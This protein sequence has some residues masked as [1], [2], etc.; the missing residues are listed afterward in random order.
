M[1]KIFKINKKY[2]AENFG[3]KELLLLEQFKKLKGLVC[4]ENTREKII[5]PH[6]P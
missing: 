2:Q 1:T 6:F 4:R 5:R 3:T